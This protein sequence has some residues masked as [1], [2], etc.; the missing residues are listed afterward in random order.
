M[1]LKVLV[2][3]RIPTY[4]GRVTMTPV[5][6]VANTYDMVRA[7]VPITEG[8]PINKALFDNK[9]YAVMED[10]TVYVSTSGND[11]TGDGS[12]DAPFA[13]IQKAIDGIPKV[14]DGHTV[15][16][17]IASGTYNE[18]ILVDGFT[19]GKLIIGVYGRNVTVKGI[20][21][22]S[23]SNVETNIQYITNSN[24]FNKPL[25]LADGGSK[26]LISS[27]MQIDAGGDTTSGISA[28]NGSSIFVQFNETISVSNCYGAAVNADKCSLVSLAT[29]TG[30]ENVVGLAAYRGGI[31]SYQK[32]EMQNMWGN[33]ADSG[34][35]VLT[36]EN[37]SELSGA[38]L[39]L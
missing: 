17:D 29:I 16:V 7:D 20:E 5:A 12:V 25:Y 4:P 10:V 37:S 15:T 9:A 11:I 26:V 28:T 23:C 32:N 14:L 31:I 36:G 33:S 39:D 24:N 2:E 30:V 1:R 34:G 8:T 27:A 18:R 6:G 3:D 21:I 13:T 19:G 22:V 35:L 38:T